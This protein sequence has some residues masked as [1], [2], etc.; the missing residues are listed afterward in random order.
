MSN[1]RQEWVQQKVQ[2]AERLYNRECSGSYPES[3]LITSAVINAIAT[4][5][6]GGKGIDKKRFVE[7]L[8]KYVKIDP[9]PTTVSVPLLVQD[10]FGKGRKTEAK[11]LQESYLDIC[12]SLVIT[13][14][15]VDKSE[16]EIQSLCP[17]LEL[18]TLR[19]NCYAT[20]FY[21]EVRSGYVH[22]Y[23]PGER[24]DSHPMTG[25]RDAMVSYTNTVDKPRRI[26]FQINWLKKIALLAAKNVDSLDLP[27][28]K[29]TKWWIEG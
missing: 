3:V 20:I 18:S 21:E 17:S 23:S 19:K 12:D 26:Y 6:W 24:S 10:L 1:W 28:K 22:E 9:T 15:N 2:I 16:I 27:L 13:G 4:E 25:A 8:V 5:L 14:N 29:P 7:L 11:L